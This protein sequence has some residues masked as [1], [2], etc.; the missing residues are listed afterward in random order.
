MSAPG[1]SGALTTV[2]RAAPLTTRRPQ[3]GGSSASRTI[4]GPAA[5][6]EK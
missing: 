3:V 5:T 2:R 6:I 1:S 4:P